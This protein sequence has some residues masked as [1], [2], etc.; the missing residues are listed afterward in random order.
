MSKHH[1]YQMLEQI[2]IFESIQCDLVSEMGL[3]TIVNTPV[4]NNV[5]N[6]RTFSN[7][8]GTCNC[9]TNERVSNRLRESNTFVQTYYFLFRELDYIILCTG[10]VLIAL[11]EMTIFRF[12]KTAYC[13]PSRSHLDLTQ[14]CSE[15]TSHCIKCH[16]VSLTRA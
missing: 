14:F 11:V 1:Q 12:H 13:L 10:T 16:D 6:L 9:R 5:P 2:Y 15:L 8:T 3:K 7:G 4:K